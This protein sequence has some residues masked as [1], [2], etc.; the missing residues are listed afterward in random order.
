[1]TTAVTT[2]Q[3]MQTKLRV[4]DIAKGTT[5]DGPGLR[6]SVYLAGCTHNCPGCHNPQSHDFNGGTEM[7]VAELMEII[8]EEDFNVTLSGGDPLCSP[9]S[10]LP[11]LKAT[12]EA[13]YDVWVYTGY[14]YEEI[15]GDPVLAPLLEYIDTLV[16]GPYIEAQ[17][18]RDL[19]FRGSANQRI[20]H[21]KDGEARFA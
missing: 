13:G 21:L 2:E 18:D 4:L 6:T 8:I 1:M 3:E 7:S 16:D 20:I 10:T 9:S 15:K 19:L 11:L 14:T 12:K 17:R 5:V